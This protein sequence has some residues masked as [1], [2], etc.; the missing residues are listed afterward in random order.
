M[1]HLLELAASISSINLLWAREETC[2]KIKKKKK[3]QEKQ[4]ARDRE[5]V[6]VQVHCH[7]DKQQE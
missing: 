6:L 5:H 1:I 2:N 3:D 7:R 4:E